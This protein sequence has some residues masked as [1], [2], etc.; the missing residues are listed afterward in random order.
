MKVAVRYPDFYLY[1][2]KVPVVF[3][4][5]VSDW[6]V[7]EKIED[8]PCFTEALPI[9]RDNIA[10]R[11]NRS[12]TGTTVIGLVKR[13]KKFST[14]LL[15]SVI[16]PLKGGDGIFDLDG[17]FLYDKQYRQL[18][19]VH[20]YFNRIV[21]ADASG[22]VLFRS[23]TIDTVS[24]PKTVVK[25][26][27][28]NTVIKMSITPPYVNRNATAARGILYVDSA[29][30]GKYEDK[31]SWEI[32]STVDAYDLL[33]QGQY[34]Y[35]FYIPTHNGSRMRDFLTANGKVIALYEDEL[36]CYELD[37]K[38]KAFEKQ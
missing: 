15:D 30:K 18:L 19:Y 17:I 16:V 32:A 31:K 25:K 20:Y 37:K 2:G 34:M 28:N 9:N 10:F 6:K 26:V 22:K 5:S 11:G 27:K 35:S 21:S 36:I 29:L 1:N 3:R 12:V 8:L 4:G 7:T 33:N 23:K 13:E 14:K 24:K 38:L